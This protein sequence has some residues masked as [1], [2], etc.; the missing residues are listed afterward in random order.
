MNGDRFHPDTRRAATVHLRSALE[1]AI[2]EAKRAVKMIDLGT[3]ST[4]AD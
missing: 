2:T 3:Y 4:V 1:E